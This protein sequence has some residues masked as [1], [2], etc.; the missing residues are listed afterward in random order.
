MYTYRFSI[1]TATYNRA[2]YLTRL[3]NS[4]LSQDY[5]DF[6]WII[7]DDGSTDDTKMLCESF[8]NQ[9]K[10][11]IIYKYKK[12]GGK[13]TAWREATKI[14]KGQYI[15]AIDSDDFL[16]SDALKIFDSNWKK[17]ENTDNY[18]MFW[19]I[20]GQCKDQFGN[21]IGG[22]LPYEIFDCNDF[23]IVYKY[24]CN[25]EMEG[26][27]KVEVLKN[28][29][30][31][32]DNFFL[33]E[34]CN[35][36]PESI[37]W[38]SASLKFQ[39]RFISDIVRIYNVGTEDSFVE[40]KKGKQRNI[41]HTYNTLIGSIEIINKFGDKIFKINLFKFIKEICICIYQSNIL[42]INPLI[43]ILNKK[44]KFLIVVLWIPISIIYLIRK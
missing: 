33:E 27:R 44:A 16:T 42:N 38:F 30:K 36:Y 9:K 1:F 4:I 7:I 22:K 15:I 37:R 25:W 14:F 40:S 32:P 3:Y 21:K 23:D 39:T 41:K 28:E 5:N 31:V 29:A 20:K 8:I 11:N 13:H 24:F 6:E 43:Y 2:K 17:L 35:N 12:N 10:I 18:E 34:K 19:E 26:C